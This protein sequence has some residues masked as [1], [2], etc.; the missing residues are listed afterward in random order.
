MKNRT[1]AALGAAAIVAALA[2]PL[3]AQEQDSTPYAGLEVREIKALS[4][5]QVEAYRLGSGMGLAL[6]AELNRHPGP[7]H[8]LELAH[9]LQLTENQKERTRSVFSAMELSAIEIGTRILEME[10]KL[11]E[12]F[13]SASLSEEEMAEIV[14]RIAIHQGSLRATHLKAH[15]EMVRI[16]SSE[17][18]E[19]YQNLRGYDQGGH[20]GAHSPE[21]HQMEKHSGH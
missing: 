4:S 20:D 1:S 9:E 18:I 8:V 11:D 16:L 2:V 13:A 10:T 14:N 5:D 19:R 3:P 6:A 15:L 12:R 17:Q 7:K 21:H